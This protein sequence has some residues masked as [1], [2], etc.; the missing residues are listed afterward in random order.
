MFNAKLM[1]VPLLAQVLLTALVWLWMYK[2]RIAEIQKN[3]ISPQALENATEAASLLKAVAAPSDN[4]SNQ[5]E[6]PVLFYLLTVTAYVTQTADS[7]LLGLAVLYVLLR[8][9][10][11]LIHLFYNRVMWRFY[12]YVSS[13]IVLWIMWLV[14]AARILRALS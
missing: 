9:L 14:T 4:F 5:F 2:T 1:F 6:M 7:M 13:C 10:H 3:S 11:S 12:A 8:Y